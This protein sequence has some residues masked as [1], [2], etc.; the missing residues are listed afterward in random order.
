VLRLDWLPDIPRPHRPGGPPVWLAGATDAALARTGRRYDGWIPYPPDPADYAS[1]L[2]W[3]RSAASDAGRD[4]YDI[5]PALYLTVVLDDDP[6]RGR[7]TAEEWC[8]RWYELPFDMVSSVQAPIW[9]YHHGA[10]ARRSG[11][12][13]LCSRSGAF[14]VSGVCARSAE[15]YRR[16]IVPRAGVDRMEGQCCSRTGTIDRSGTPS[17]LSPGGLCDLR[18][19]TVAQLRRVPAGTGL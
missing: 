10:T 15:R 8:L 13:D 2:A 17:H 19:P 16:W 3:L 12:D 18:Y 11:A 7:T 4:P 6:E 1:G 5:T 14:R 9:R